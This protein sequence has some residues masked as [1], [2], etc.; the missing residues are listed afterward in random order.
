MWDIQIAFDDV[1]T[2]IEDPSLI[3]ADFS[4]PVCHVYLI[5]GYS[6]S[7]SFCTGMQ[8]ARDALPPIRRDLNFRD[9]RADAPSTEGSLEIP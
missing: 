5:F 4:S 8:M 2:W 9:S 1:W 3:S 6:K 7:R